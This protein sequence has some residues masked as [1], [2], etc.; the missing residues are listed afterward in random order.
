MVA[1]PTTN[2]NGAAP[3]PEEKREDINTIRLDSADDEHVWLRFTAHASRRTVKDLNR[4]AAAKPTGDTP[5]EIEAATDAAD[6]AL[7]EAVK[8]IIVDGSVRVGEGEVKSLS[9][10]E[11]IADLELDNLT[12]MS[13]MFY[14]RAAFVAI[15]TMA[16]LGN[17]QRPG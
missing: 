5:E 4:L 16:N 14:H 13:D 17:P 15:Q 3:K 9:D 8:R 11:A 10:P 1:N 6:L 7:F 12:Y 2:M